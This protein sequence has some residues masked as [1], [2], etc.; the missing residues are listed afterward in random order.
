MQ[1]ACT[2]AANWNVDAY[3]FPIV[4]HA[5]Q[6]A[7]ALSSSNRGTGFSDL[8]LL[9]RCVGLSEVAVCCLHAASR[10]LPKKLNGLSYGTVSS[11]ASLAEGAR[12]D[13]IMAG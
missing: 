2:D 10:Q 1:G 12:A 7:V 6:R 8:L 9:L 3:R 4:Q 11:T 13:A 5:A